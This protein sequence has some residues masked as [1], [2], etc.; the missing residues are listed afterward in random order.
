MNI[1][2]QA[3]DANRV[4]FVAMP[5]SGDLIDEVAEV[6]QTQVNAPKSR[7]SVRTRKPVP[8]Y[9]LV[10]DRRPPVWQANIYAESGLGVRPTRDSQYCVDDADDLVDGIRTGAVEV[11]KDSPVESNKVAIIALAISA[12]IFVLCGLVAIRNNASESLPV[13]AGSELAS[14][15]V[16]EEGR[17]QYGIVDDLGEAAGGAASEQAEETGEQGGGGGAAGGGDDSGS[18][19]EKSLEP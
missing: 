4:R 7:A 12:A 8:L 9:H 11:D 19:P 17:V 15:T 16:A 6:T 13:E 2:S 3:T 1:F 14:E 18:G 10:R 5:E